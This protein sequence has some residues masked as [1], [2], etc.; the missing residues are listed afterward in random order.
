MKKVI[1]RIDQKGSQ[2]GVNVK[3]FYKGQ[4]YTIT[5]WLA[6]V[7]LAENWANEVTTIETTTPE[8]LKKEKIFTPESI[9]KPQKKHKR[10]SK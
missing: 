4:V 5:D 3:Q 9:A 7:F 8:T 2:D 1:M 10:K 6:E